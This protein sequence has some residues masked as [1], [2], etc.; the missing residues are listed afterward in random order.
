MMQSFGIEATY[1]HRK[2][3][4]QRHKL[5]L[6]IQDDRRRPYIWPYSKLVRPMVPKLFAVKTIVIHILNAEK[7]TH[8][9]WRQMDPYNYAEHCF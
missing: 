7:V 1:G 4:I 5:Y 8:T 2:K 3:N 6:K 9:K